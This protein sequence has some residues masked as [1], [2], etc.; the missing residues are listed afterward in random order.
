MT[1]EVLLLS[2]WTGRRRDSTTPVELPWPGYKGGDRVRDHRPG[3]VHI[4]VRG[5][6][7]SGV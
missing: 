6:R 3:K 7:E 1:R 4:Q 2:S 5:H